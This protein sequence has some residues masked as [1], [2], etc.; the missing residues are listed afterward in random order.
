M[1][2]KKAPKAVTTFT[3]AEVEKTSEPE[4]LTFD[5]STVEGVTGELT[6]FDETAPVDLSLESEDEDTGEDVQA[7]GFAVYV[8]GNLNI[9]SQ[10]VTIDPIAGWQE[11]ES[12][13]DYQERCRAV[14]H[15]MTWFVPAIDREVQRLQAEILYTQRELDAQERGALNR[16]E[17]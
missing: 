12:G 6:G 7:E 15:R 17:R 4:V 16:V 10:E 2:T 5:P 13:Q 11:G 14:I 8:Q 9:T 3:P 1:A